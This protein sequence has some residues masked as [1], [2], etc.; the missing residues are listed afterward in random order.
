MFV[1][2]IFKLLIA[3]SRSQGL[4][5][6]RTQTFIF[7]DNLE[8]DCKQLK[9]KVCQKAFQGNITSRILPDILNL[10][11]PGELKAVSGD[12]LHLCNVSNFNHKRCI[13]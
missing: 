3:T 8:V 12:V 10:R 2:K 13:V 6:F 1:H 9:S 5:K 4:H 7:T 11:F